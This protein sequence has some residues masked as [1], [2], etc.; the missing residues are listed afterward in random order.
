MRSPRSSTKS[1][2]RSPQLEKARTQQ[3]RPNAAENKRQEKKQKKKK[4]RQIFSCNGLQA[5]FQELPLFIWAYSLQ[6]HTV[7]FCPLKHATHSLNR[8]ILNTS[9][10]MLYAKRSTEAKPD[11]IPAAWQVRGTLGLTITILSLPG[12]NP[13]GD[14]FSPTWLTFS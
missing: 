1:S 2:P 14:I 7:N 5:A 6:N 8:P 11:P 4:E 9:P 12:E 13:S 3:Q 10:E